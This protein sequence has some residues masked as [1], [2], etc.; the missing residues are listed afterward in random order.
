MAFKINWSDEAI[1]TFNDN[2][3]Y[4]EENWSENDITH[5]I[6]KTVDTLYLIKESPLIFKQSIK[7]KSIRKAIVVKQVSLFY[8]I[9]NPKNTIELITFWNNYKNQKKLKLR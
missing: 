8:K 1:K 6:N 5:F 9:N 2:I 7:S 4:L 3:K